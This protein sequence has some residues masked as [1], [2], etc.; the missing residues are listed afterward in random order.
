MIFNTQPR[1]LQ[2]AWSVLVVRILRLD[3]LF[4][5]LF[6]TCIATLA[7]SLI[8]AALS[9]IYFFEYHPSETIGRLE[10]S[11]LTYRLAST[12]R[13]DGQGHPLSV[14][15]PAEY[16]TIHSEFSEDTGYQII[17]NQ[18]VVIFSS[19]TFAIP[20]EYIG[21]T[22]KTG[23]LPFQR[24]GFFFH[25]E[26]TP[27]EKAR[28]TYFMQVATSERL[29]AT[30]AKLKINMILR[31]IEI[32]FLIA[33]AIFAITMYATFSRL[34]DPIKKASA[35]AIGITPKNLSE[36][37]SIRGIP[38][39]LR[40]L[41]ES[42]NDALGRLEK[43]YQSQQIFLASAAHELQTPLTL[44]RGQV[45]M[46]DVAPNKSRIL[47]D[48]DLMSRQVRQILHLVEVSEARNYKF[49][50]IDFHAVIKDVVNYLS[51]RLEA[52]NIFVEIRS[53]DSAL[54]MQA[55]EGALFTLLKNLL[56]NAVTFAPNNS[57]VEVG[58]DDS[59]ITIR[60]RGIGI[61]KEHIPFIF[62]RFW[63]AP[64]NKHEGAGL[65]LAICEQIARAHGWQIA[66]ER[67]N[68]GTQFV[69]SFKH[70]W[71]IASSPHIS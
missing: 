24:N 61:E 5:K 63:R 14:V 4:A 51:P 22:I 31:V 23:R 66:A 38:S 41:V 54:Y 20:V 56:E 18:G 65:G 68:P 12:V 45:E 42:F 16:E 19:S 11:R 6:V 1:A 33:T 30:F 15:L 13:L 57:A 7:F 55:D 26:T 53:E 44:I 69:I 49:S 25:V 71:W 64:N 43:E 58:A 39:E 40:P 60:D 62:T 17:N 3:S 70:P 35:S 9:V 47:R 21:G 10:V 28:G 36:R 34:I 2:T 48:V 52:R 32:C 29:D 37:L 67:M 46:L 59:S 27:I 8:L 50:R